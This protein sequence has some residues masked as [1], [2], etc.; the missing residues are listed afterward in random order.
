MGTVQWHY[1]ETIKL[2]APLF[3]QRNGQCMAIRILSTI[4]AAFF[5]ASFACAASLAA[6][7]KR[8]MVLHSFGRDVKPWS[9][10]SKSIRTELERHRHGRW[11]SL[12]NR[13]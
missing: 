4:A 9:Q 12:I 6:E 5:V 2:A 3:Y 10:Y 7:P 11:R 13:L 1:L 8:V